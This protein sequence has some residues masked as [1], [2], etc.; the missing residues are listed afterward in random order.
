VKSPYYRGLFLALKAT[1]AEER[2]AGSDA[3]L[4][5]LRAGACALIDPV[6]H[7]ED[8]LNIG[9]VLVEAQEK[10]GLWDDAATQY[11]RILLA[12]RSLYDAQATARGR[13]EVLEVHGR[14]PRWAAYAFARAGR[15]ARAAEVIEAGRATELSVMVARE[16]LEL[17]R[18]LGVDPALVERY[19]AAYQQHRIAVGA[20][21]DSVGAPTVDSDDDRARAANQALKRVLNEIRAIPTFESFAREMTIEDIAVA[22]EDLAG[23]YLIVSP[24][25]SYCVTVVAGENGVE[26]SAVDVREVTGN[27]I[28]NIAIM[29][30]DSGRLGLLA[31]QASGYSLD[32]PL[33]DLVRLAP[34][35]T[36]I[37]SEM[38]R[39]EK[40]AVVLVPTG[41]MG[42]VPLAAIP[43]STDQ[44]DYLDDSVELQFAP[45][46]AL[47][48]TC[49]RRAKFRRPP[50]FVGVADADSNFPLPG[51]RAELETL[52]NLFATIGK[53]E[54]AAGSAV[55]LSWILNKATDCTHLHFACHGYS[56]IS[57]PFGG[58]LLL[59][60]NEKLTVRELAHM[61]GLQPRLVVASACQSGHVGGDDAL[62]EFVGL[63]AGF[64]ESGAACAVVSLWPVS[65]ESTALLMT[66]FYDGMVIDDLSP[67]A[68]L[69]RARRW[70][71]HLTNEDREQYLGQKPALAAA[72][73]RNRVAT[74]A[75][76]TGRV[77][78]YSSPEQWAAFVA[79]G[80]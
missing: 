80:Y 34:L 11:E 76:G 72:L 65:D 35:A 1:M 56:D 44:G 4:L 17:E 33:A 26:L 61:S 19:R 5:S 38:K 66:K 36:A 57:Q 60:N 75:R 23:C 25:G 53:V 74:P 22:L 64:L 10:A 20:R 18:L 78:P 6:L 48:R 70:L 31:A 13:Q 59:A 51:S 3:D 68:A 45:S 69:R 43:L 28:A 47:Y 30:F 41:L 8:H 24:Y 16:S 62:D 29:D 52:S 37:Y 39:L 77:Y 42:F 46:L 7:P 21:F 9:K 79:Y 15:Y 14:V 55:T 73:R 63:A 49:R 58:A 12:F 50:H 32:V 54:T 27:L 40:T 71:R 2:Q 67:H